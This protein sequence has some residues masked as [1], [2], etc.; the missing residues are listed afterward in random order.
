MA[1]YPEVQKKAQADIDQLV[2]NRLP[3]VED[4][5]SLSYIKALIKEVVRWGPVIPLGLPNAVLKDDVYE[6]YFIPKGTT[7]HLNIW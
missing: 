2:S 1:L 5:N 3:T 6:N 7:V 4:F